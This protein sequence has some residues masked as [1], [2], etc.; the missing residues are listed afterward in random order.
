VSTTRPYRLRPL[1]FLCVVVLLVV[2]AAAPAAAAPPE[3]VKGQHGHYLFNDVESAPLVNCHYSGTNPAKLHKFVVKRPLAWWS[4]LG[5]G[6]QSGTVGWQIRMQAAADP[7]SGPWTTVYTS[8]I[9][10]KVAKEDDPLYDAADAAAFTTPGILWSQAGTKSYR[11]SSKVFWYFPAGTGR[12]THP[13]SWY[14]Q[15]GT[16]GGPVADYCVN[17]L[18]PL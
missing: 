5:P 9:L 16:L 10:K 3:V 6:T 2:N 4:D 8:T 1:V 7:D 14:K 12:V 11:V 17:K 13:M 15:T 18:A